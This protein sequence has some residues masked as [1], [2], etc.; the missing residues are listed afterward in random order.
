MGDNARQFVTRVHH[1][2]SPPTKY[3]FLFC[4]SMMTILL[5]WRVTGDVVTNHPVRNQRSSDADKIAS[6][7]ILSVIFMDSN[8]SHSWHVKFRDLKKCSSAWSCLCSLS[9][10]EF[11]GRLLWTALFSMTHGRNGA[12]VWVLPDLCGGE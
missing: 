8:S 11:A 6:S 5:C 9:T 3:P 7:L 1:Q 2:F 12:A 10:G 4:G